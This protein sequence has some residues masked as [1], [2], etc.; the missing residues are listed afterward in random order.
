MTDGR[1]WVKEDLTACD[2]LIFDGRDK[3]PCDAFVEVKID[4]S[5]IHRSKLQKDT[6]HPIFNESFQ[7]GW[8]SR[9]TTIVFQMIDNDWSSDYT[10]SAQQDI[11]STW[12]GNAE[13]FLSRDVLGEYGNL[14]RVS[15]KLIPDDS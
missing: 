3:N 11:M 5:L 7:T 9:N 15:T 10:S 13:Y 2:T 1:A 12:S 6:D 8:I 14:L 4:Y